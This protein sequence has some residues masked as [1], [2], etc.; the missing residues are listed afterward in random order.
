MNQARGFRKNIKSYIIE[1][2]LFKNGVIILNFIGQIENYNPEN[3]Q[4]RNEKRIILEYIKQFPDNILLRENEF[5][6]MTSSG[7]IM[8]KSLDKVLMIHHNIYNTW[9]WTG[10]HAD[11]DT[12]LLYIALKEAKEET[13]VINIAPLFEDIASLDVLPVWSHIRRGKYVCAH[14]HL[15]SSYILI[16]DES[17]E[18]KVNRNETSGVRWIN[19]NDIEK[20]SN[21]SNMILVY[22]RLIQKARK[23]S[24]VL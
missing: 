14:L 4:E 8:S 23:Y 10:G 13:G 15:N 11:G 1:K 24:G 2:D 16:V 12:D 3:D 18:L 6:H 9:A 5:A 21:E 17:E 7:F 20:F 22:N 19:V